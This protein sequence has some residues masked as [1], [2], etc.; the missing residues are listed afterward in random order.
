MPRQMPKQKPGRSRQNYESPDDLILAVE[1]HF[2]SID[3]DLAASP[4]NAKAECYYTKRQNSLTK[5]WVGGEDGHVPNRS[6]T[7]WLNPPYA[8]IEP[9]VR[10]CER[11][12]FSLTSGKILVLVPASVGSIWF[13]DWVWHKA[14]VFFLTSRPCFIRNDSYPKDVMLLE[15]RSPRYRV[16]PYADIWD[17]KKA[18]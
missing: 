10:K 1:R 3:F 4:S 14:R 17:W 5:V 8:H 16:R 9:W 18:E 7:F 13:R 15:Y 2:G 11:E 12:R 6:F